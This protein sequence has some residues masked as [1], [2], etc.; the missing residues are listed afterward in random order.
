MNNMHLSMSKQ[1]STARHSR[2]QLDELATIQFPA[3]QLACQPPVALLWQT[4]VQLVPCV[5]FVQLKFQPGL[6]V[7][8]TLGSPVQTRAAIHHKHEHIVS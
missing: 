3:T 1:L 6:S 2:S 4:A 8:V 7:G 5:A